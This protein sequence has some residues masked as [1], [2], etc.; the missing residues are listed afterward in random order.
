MTA[1]TDK[2]NV[3]ASGEMCSLIRNSVDELDRKTFEAFVK[4]YHDLF[5]FHATQRLTTFNFF[6]LSLT[7]ASNAYAL[8]ITRWQ[9]NEKFLL[10]GTLA[11]AAFALIVLFNRLDARNEQIIHINEDAIMCIQLA[12]KEKFQE[13]R[14][15][16]FDRSNTERRRFTTFGEIL[17]SIY[18][19]AS[20][21]AALGA[22]YAFSRYVESAVRISKA[23][24]W[25]VSILLVLILLFF[26]CWSSS[27]CRNSSNR[28]RTA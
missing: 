21:V 16:T 8:L 23:D 20:L 26:S 10:A 24:I 9:D 11:L 18:I 17:P 12:L 6:L 28:Y 3:H 15:L 1:D 7:L 2:V 25:A 13:Q 22:V 27:Q 5:S 19:L 4:H 14:L